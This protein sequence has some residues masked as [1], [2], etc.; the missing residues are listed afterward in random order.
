[1]CRAREIAINVGVT[2]CRIRKGVGDGQ[3]GGVMFELT[4][5]GAIG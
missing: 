5:Y 1:M 4:C 3:I 2:W